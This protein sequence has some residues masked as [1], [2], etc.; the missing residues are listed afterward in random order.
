M[1]APYTTH[2]TTDELVSD[3]APLI[4]DKVILTTGV[5]SGSLGGFFVQ[6][7]AKAK[8]AWL[9]LAARNADKLAQMAADITTAQHEIQVRTLQ[10]DLGSLKSVQEAAAQVNNSWDDIPVIDVL[11]N[12]AGIMAVDYQLSPEGFESHLATNHLGPFLFTNLIMKKIVAAK[13]PRI[14]MVSSDGHRLNPFRFHDYNFDKLGIKHDLQAFSLH[15]GV[16]WTN[17][18]N[19]LDWSV[20]LGELRNADKSLGNPEGWKEFDAKPLERGAATHIYAAFDPCLKA[21]NG[22]YLIDCRVSDPL[23]DTVKPWATSSFEAERLWRL[24]ED[25][26]GQEFSY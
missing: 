8:P 7:I 21:N 1:P 11:V 12:N 2:T 18:G 23:V 14:V 6:A 10:V 24:S 19:H 4:K 16:I 22:V 26:V 9:I 25:L 13:E 20:E 15:P 3:Y 5:S 17:L